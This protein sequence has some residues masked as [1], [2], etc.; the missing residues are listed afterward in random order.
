MWPN[1]NK[2]GPF[3]NHLNNCHGLKKKYASFDFF[4]ILK[5]SDEII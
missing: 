3:R 2:P 5:K 1:L 4:Y